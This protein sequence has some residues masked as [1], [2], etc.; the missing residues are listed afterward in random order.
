MYD[1]LYEHVEWILSDN[2]SRHRDGSVL[3]LA[4]VLNELSVG[5]DKGKT[6][7]VCFYDLSKAFDRVWYD[8]LL[9]KLHH[10]GVRK[11]ALAWLKEYLKE[12]KQRVRVG[13]V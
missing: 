9:L 3:Q 2:Q 8:G 7:M 13:E 11:S 6:T 5:I 10:Y 12:R 1:K 4:K